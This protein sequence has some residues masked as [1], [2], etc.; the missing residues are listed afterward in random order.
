MIP[1]LKIKCKKNQYRQDG[2]CAYLGWKTSFGWITKEICLKQKC[3][4]YDGISK[5]CTA[6]KEQS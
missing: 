1:L 5:E 4:Y 2:T 6:A 3:I